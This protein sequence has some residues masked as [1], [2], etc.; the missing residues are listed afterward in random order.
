MLSA[1]G[2]VRYMQAC[3]VI[4]RAPWAP[5]AA[6]NCQK[7]KIESGRPRWSEP[8]TCI[9]FADYILTLEAERDPSHSP[10]MH[11][12]AARGPYSP[13]PQNRFRSAPKGPPTRL[14]ALCW[15]G[16]AV[17]EGSRHTSAFVR[18]HRRHTLPHLPKR[19]N[20]ARS[21]L[22]ERATHIRP[23]C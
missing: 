20:R 21:T 18:P 6:L 3:R 11:S 2:R 19:Q 7:D 23:L 16:R 1:R 22:M 5:Q 17:L 10:T 8:P 14:C 12:G 4:C 15:L 9:R 13:K